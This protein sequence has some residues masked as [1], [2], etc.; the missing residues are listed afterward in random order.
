MVPP[1]LLLPVPRRRPRWLRHVGGGGLGGC[2]SVYLPVGARLMSAPL[3][4]TCFWWQSPQ[5]RQRLSMSVGPSCSQWMMWCGWQTLLDVPQPTQPRSRAARAM[6]WA[7]L[8]WRCS[9]PNQSGCS[10]A[11]KRAGR[12]FA[13]S[14]SLSSSLA[15]TG[16]PS[17]EAGVSELPGDGVVVGDHQ[18]VR[19]L[20]LAGTVAGDQQLQRVGETLRGGGAVLRVL[21]YPEFLSAI[22]ASAVSMRFPAMGSNLPNSS[23]MPSD[24][25]ERLTRRCARWRFRR[26][27]RSSPERSLT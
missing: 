17:D 26:S 24:F 6:R 14:A 23:Y 8:A 16:V 20:R 25:L 7:S 11:S 27:S 5:S 21:G 4:W 2:W 9:R 3:V 13:S 19:A 15:A 10:L 12:I 22:A 1:A 18:Q